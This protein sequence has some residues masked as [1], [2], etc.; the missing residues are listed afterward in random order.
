MWNAGTLEWL[1]NGNYSNRSI[2]IVHSREPL[3]DDPQLADHVEQGRYYLP[4]AP[5]GQRET[6]RHPAR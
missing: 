1:P 2:P 3:W 6:H 4:N 5:T